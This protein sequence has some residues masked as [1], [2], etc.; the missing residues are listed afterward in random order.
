MIESAEHEELLFVVVPEGPHAGET[1][2][3]VVERVRQEPDPGVGVGNDLALEKC[4]L[5][6]NHF[7]TSSVH[8]IQSYHTLGIIDRYSRPIKIHLA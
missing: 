5:R 2:G 7:L 4:E 1:S 8:L 3:T 6:E